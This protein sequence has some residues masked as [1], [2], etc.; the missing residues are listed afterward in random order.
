MRGSFPHPD[1][2]DGRGATMLAH[3]S[4]RRRTAHVP[5]MNIRQPDMRALIHRAC[6]Q[7]TRFHIEAEVRRRLNNVLRGFSN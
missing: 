6:A 2:F 1:R 3:M 7:V 5:W 4:C